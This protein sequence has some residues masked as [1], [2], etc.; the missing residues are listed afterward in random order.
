M[1]AAQQGQK[2]IILRHKYAAATEWIA[3]QNYLNP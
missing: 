1:S 2:K 3:K